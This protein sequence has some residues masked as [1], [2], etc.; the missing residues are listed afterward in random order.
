MI[1]DWN[2]KR[3]DKHTPTTYSIAKTDSDA[4]SLRGMRR[5]E[6]GALD[7]YRGP[8]IFCLQRLPLSAGSFLCDC[9]RGIRLPVQPAGLSEEQYLL[10]AKSRG[11]LA[12]PLAYLRLSGPG[13]LQS[14]LTLGGGSLSSSL[15]LGVLAGYSLLWLQPLAMVL[16]IVMLSAIG[17][18]TTSTGAPPFQAVNR[19]VNPVLGWGW[20]LASLLASLV[21]SMPQYSLA[22]AVVQQNL[23]PGQFEG[24]LG[25]GF[26]VLLILVVSTAATWSYG[27][28]R[29]GVKLYEV[30][31]KVAVALIVACF[32]AVV[33]TLSLSPKGLPWQSL[34]KGFIPDPHSLLRPSSH[35]APLLHAIEEAHRP[36]WSALIVQKQTD[37]LVS[38]A[39]TAVGIN[40]TFL[41]PYSLLKRKWGKAFRGFVI[42]DLGSG[43]LVPFVIATSCVV[44]AAASQFHTQ[45][46]PG[47]AWETA[48]K[49]LGSASPMQQKEFQRLLQNRAAANESGPAGGTDSFSIAEK[50]LAATLVTRD[51]F[52]LAN[53][54][55][56][57]SGQ[58]FANL[59]FGLGV[60][61]MALS[62]ITLL[63][64][65]SGLVICEMLNLPPTGWSYRLAT[66]TAAS[67]ALGPFVWNKAAFWLAIPT[68]VFGFILLPLAYLTFL[69]LMN[70]RQVLGME[71]PR[72]GRRWTWNTLMTVA[73]AVASCGSLIMAWKKGGLWGMAAVLAVAAA[74]LWFHRRRRRKQKAPPGQEPSPGG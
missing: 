21:W 14:A 2:P 65:V 51:A 26:V 50:K 70:Q 66:L 63:M 34:L 35:Y 27:R 38:A 25:K 68:S 47:L 22:T 73:T 60:L 58:S 7:R 9:H 61:G 1:L 56:P 32:I 10:K 46:Q 4:P 8:P 64:L 40:M 11:G 13:W 71:M 67:G 31:L 74:A 15:Y 3:R 72:G 18:V 53:S 23:F 16:G 45:P 17:Y 28:G 6:D 30:I 49:R 48:E 39:A 20:A 59:V 44:I 43:M 24:A 37:V 19:H 12:L 52:D 57:L 5:R 62:T 42:F 41:F 69:L 33:I 54:L 29:I 36:Y 55:K